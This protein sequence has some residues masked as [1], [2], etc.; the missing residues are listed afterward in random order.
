MCLREASQS[1]AVS[2]NRAGPQ[3][4][5][6]PGRSSGLR[7]VQG[8]EDCVRDEPPSPVVGFSSRFKGWDSRGLLRG[9]GRGRVRPKRAEAA[10]AENLDE[11]AA[12][13][14]DWSRTVVMPTWL[15]LELDVRLESGLPREGITISFPIS[16]SQPIEETVARFLAGGLVSAERTLTEARK[17]SNAPKV[18]KRWTGG[19]P[20]H[21]PNLLKRAVLLPGLWVPAS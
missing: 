12:E 21:W 3:K 11:R 7:L 4:R 16:S 8:S 19:E 18:K 2:S 13:A 9:T 1:P 17:K 15:R 10:R 6:K 20:E 14:A 5:A